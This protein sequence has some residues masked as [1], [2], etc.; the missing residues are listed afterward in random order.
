MVLLGYLLLVAL[1]LQ[2]TRSKKGVAGYLLLVALLL[3]VTRL[4][5]RYRLPVAGY[6]ESQ[7]VTGFS[8]HWVTSQSYSFVSN[9]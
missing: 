8:C 1:L 7:V 9:E 6:L 4:K 5:R 2:V 3:Q